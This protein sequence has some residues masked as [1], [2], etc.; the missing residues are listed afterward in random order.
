MTNR[1]L[2]QKKDS[3]ELVSWLEEPVAEPSKVPA[4]NWADFPNFQPSEFLCPCG[5]CGFS[6]LEGVQDMDYKLLFIL[7]SVRKKYG[8]PMSITSG[9]RCETYNATL[10]NADKNSY[11]MKKKASD[12]YIAG[13]TSTEAGRNEVVAFMK[14]LTG[15]K[16]SYHNIGR[17][18]P[19]MGSAIHIE[20]L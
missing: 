11:H 2:L 9:A 6:T 16:Y 3:V 15:Y 13:V 14:Q 19:K 7:Q 17:K 4:T 8:K 1:E 18:Y 12:F 20:V 10:P 5:K